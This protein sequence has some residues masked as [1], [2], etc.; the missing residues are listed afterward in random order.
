MSV[1]SEQR[2]AVAEGEGSVAIAAPVRG[3]MIVTG[4]NNTVEMRLTGIGAVLAFAFRWNRPRRRPRRDRAH[5]SPPS[6][7]N[8]LDREEQVAALLAIDGTPRVVNVYGAAGIGKT[9]VLVEALNRGESAMRHGTVYLDGR[10][11][12]ADDLLHAVF[13]EFYECRVQRRD[14]RIERLLSSRRAVLALE[15][16]DLSPDAAQRLALGAPRC[17][18]LVTSESRVLFDATPVSLHGLAPEYAVAI[19]EQELGR[20]LGPS[21]R[22]LAESIA[23]RL[24]GHPLALRQ[25]FSRARDEGRGRPLDELQQEPWLMAMPT[26]ADRLATLTAPQLRA[27]RALAVHGDAALG[28]E[29]LR[30]IAGAETVAAAT[31]LVTRH[32]AIS[33]SPR[34]SLVGVLAQTLPQDDLTEETARALEHFTRWSETHV[35]DSEA[36]LREAA[37]LLALLERA[38]AAQRWT[39][40][41]R[42]GRAIEGAYAL[43]QRWADWGRVLELVLDAAL[44]HE[45]LEAE[46]WARHQLGTRAYGLGQIAAAGAMLR[47]ALTLRERIGDRDGAAATRQNLRV[48]SGPTPLLYRLSHVSLTVVAIVCTLLVGTVGVAAAGIVPGGGDGA[49]QLTIGIQ[50]TGLVVSDDGSIRCADSECHQEITGHREVLLRPQA[51][52]GWE[53]ARWTE[54]CSGRSTC[55]LNVTGD[56]R[57]VALFNRV[58][59]PREVLVRIQGEGTVVSRPAGI[60][61]RADDTCRATFTRSRQVRLAAAAAPGHRF[62]GWSGGCE[63]TKRCTVTGDDRQTLVRA[64]FVADPAAVTLTVDLRGDGQGLVT[65]RQSG[66]DC[67]ELCAA[68]YREGSRVALTAIAQPGSRFSGWTDPSCPSAAAANTCTVAIDQDRNVLA[69][70][71]RLP[72][73]PPRPAPPPAPGP[74]PPTITGSGDQ[75]PPGALSV[76]ITSPAEGRVFPA[77]ERI[78][79]VAEVSDPR[80]AELDALVWSEDGIKIGNGRQITRAKTPSGTHRIEVAATTSDGRSD[81][82]D[83]TIRVEAPPNRAPRV[84]I[85]HPPNDQAYEAQ[86]DPQSEPDTPRYY[87]DVQ[88]TATAS[89]PD[90]DRLQYRWTDRKGPATALST[91]LSPSLRLDA[92]G[93]YDLVLTVSDGTQSSTASVRVSVYIARERQPETTPTPPPPPPPSVIG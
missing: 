81:Y 51:R 10:G 78:T 52:P 13:D 50:G 79:Y 71:E 58:R 60:A 30:A 27:A 45:D 72:N 84:A 17:R 7:D 76:R 36:L 47:E 43:G 92:P 70:F 80:N 25:I 74:A 35:G 44:R 14:L 77:G 91:Q 93:V 12:S 32:D 19:A 26:A 55:R 90:G 68:S 46:G 67:G 86:Y 9:H 18:F 62:T 29:H 21:E 63:G 37:A 75:P 39:D 2:L 82:A 28:D 66:I 89:D 20:P 65:S 83:V 42:L 61:C 56:T 3:A 33:H 48:V 5:G 38:H 6:F 53:F 49:A 54:A 23:A 8:H 85:T 88:L 69:R 57:A 1:A 15:D 11:Q 59:D 34:H 40:V 73:A 24:S 16:V 22:R 87:K 31:E 4:H 64:R 41:I